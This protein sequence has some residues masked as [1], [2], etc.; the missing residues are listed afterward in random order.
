[1]RFLGWVVILALFGT[2]AHGL[3]LDVRAIGPFLAVY[4]FAIITMNCAPEM[5]GEESD[6]DVA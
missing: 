4:L 5:Y 3:W 2:A 6:D 1:M